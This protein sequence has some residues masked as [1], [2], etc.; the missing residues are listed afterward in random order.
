MVSAWSLNNWPATP[1]TK[2]SGRNTATVVSVDAVTAMLTSFVPRYTASASSS[3]DRLC[4][5]M[6]SSTTMELST[7]MPIPRAIPPSDMM[8]SVRSV[9]YIRANVAMIEM[10]MDRPIISVLRTSLRKR[11]RMMVASSPPIQALLRTS[12]MAC[13]MKSA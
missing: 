4:R 2:T 11:N 7:S 6:A 8:F 12:P 13:S 9:W 3:P 1:S 5:S 10:G